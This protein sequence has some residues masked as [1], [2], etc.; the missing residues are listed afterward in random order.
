MGRVLFQFFT[1]AA[2][3]NHQRVFISIEIV[4]PGGL[5][6]R[7]AGYDAIPVLIELLEKC[8]LLGGEGPLPA[9]QSLDK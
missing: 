7:I 4:P 8:K 9:I 3:M 5:A 1:H 6:E 2:D